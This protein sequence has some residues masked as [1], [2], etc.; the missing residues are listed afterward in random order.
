[1]EQLPGGNALLKGANSF[2]CC[3]EVRCWPDCRLSVSTSSQSAGMIVGSSACDATRVKVRFG[4]A[5][6]RKPTQAAGRSSQLLQA[7]VRIT[8]RNHGTGSQSSDALQAA[9]QALV[10]PLVLLYGNAM[11]AL[12]KQA[13]VRK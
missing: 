12:A 4:G 13:T 7:V 10:S 1:M 2:Y 5:C 6:C 3:K 9:A 8:A 11:L